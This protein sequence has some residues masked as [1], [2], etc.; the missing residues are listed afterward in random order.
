MTRDFWLGRQGFHNS[1]DFDL[2]AQT[3]D[4]LAAAADIIIPGHDNYFLVHGPGG[5]RFAGP[6]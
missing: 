4:Q 2:A 3:M 1:V 6:F 5:D